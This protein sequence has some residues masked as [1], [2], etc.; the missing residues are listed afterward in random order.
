MKR[1]SRIRRRHGV[2]LGVVIGGLLG[3]A[4]ALAISVF[5][6]KDPSIWWPP[7]GVAT[8]IFAGAVLGLLFTEEIK[9]EEEED[10]GTFE[11]E[12]ALQSPAATKQRSTAD[13]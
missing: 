8:G 6:P 2:A 4:V 10:L 11:A 5:G 9:G 1:S 7:A 3:G 12:D 13:R